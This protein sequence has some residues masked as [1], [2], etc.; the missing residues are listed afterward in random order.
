MW[1][2]KYE[3]WMGKL[4]KIQELYAQEHHWDFAWL[5][6]SEVYR[7][8]DEISSEMT[9]G[10]QEKRKERIMRESFLFAGDEL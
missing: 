8:M 1:D 4:V 2:G 9:R 3:E 7:R 6:R 5:E 10:Y